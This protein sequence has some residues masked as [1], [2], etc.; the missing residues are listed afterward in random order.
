MSLG[1]VD[2]IKLKTVKREAIS[3]VRWSIGHHAKRRQTRLSENGG[4]V[5]ESAKVV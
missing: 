3:P 5:H 4:V 1:D 2:I